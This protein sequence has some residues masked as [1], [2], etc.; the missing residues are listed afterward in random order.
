MEEPTGIF[1]DSQ[2]LEAERLRFLETTRGA[3][4]ARAFA[5]QTCSGYRRAVLARAAPAADPVFGLRLLASYC[6]FKR[7]LAATGREQSAGGE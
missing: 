4:A 5:R 2:A 7:Y 6:Y 3:A 1:R